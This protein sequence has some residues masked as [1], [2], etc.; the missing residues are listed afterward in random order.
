MAAMWKTAE[1]GR[2]RLAHWLVLLLQWDGEGENWDERAREF[3]LLPS[4]LSSIAQCRDEAV[5]SRTVHTHAHNNRWIRSTY[6][7]SLSSSF[8]YAILNN[9]PFSAV[10][11][12]F[13][14]PPFFSLALRTYVLIGGASRDLRGLLTRRG[15]C[16]TALNYSL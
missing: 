10:T 3:V 5:K 13:N 14:E 7:P 1:W 2:C 11:A 16:G 12:H 15:Q 6:L 9:A 4:L 8:V